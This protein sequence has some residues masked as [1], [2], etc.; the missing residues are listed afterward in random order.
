MFATVPASQTALDS[1]QRLRRVTVEALAPLAIP[2]SIGAI[3]EGSAA[4]RFELLRGAQSGAIGAVDSA[5]AFYAANAPALG[6]A[7]PVL[8]AFAT[9][10]A[11]LIA[12]FSES[13][14]LE[15]LRDRI[16]LALAMP[17][18]TPVARALGPVEAVV[19]AVDDW[20]SVASREVSLGSH[21]Q[22]CIELII[23]WRRLELSSW[24]GLLDRED[25]HVRD[26]G[27]EW[28]FRLFELTIRLPLEANA[29]LLPH[30]SLAAIEGLLRTSSVGEFSRRLD[31]IRSFAAYAAAL[32]D[33]DAGAALVGVA[34]ALDGLVSY[35][36]RFSAPAA[37]EA[38][39][40]R[41]DTMRKVKDVVR[42]ASWRDANILALR[43][44]TNRSHRQLLA[45]ARSYRDKLA[46]PASRHF[47]AEDK[48]DRPMAKLAGPVEPA[49]DLDAALIERAVA[50]GP[51][52]STSAALNG[53]GST[54]RTLDTI[55]RA[56]SDR[57]DPSVT[58]LHELADEVRD[59]A[60]GLSAEQPATAKA[61]T[62]LLTR[63]RRAWADLCQQVRRLGWAQSP[64]LAVERS[65]Q[66]RASTVVI[67]VRARVALD[68][69]T[70]VQAH[71]D[72]ATLPT[73]RSL[74]PA[75]S[76]VLPSTAG[77]GSS[78]IASVRC[79]R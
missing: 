20:E 11:A 76:R 3:D 50:A 4:Y 61:A 17:A 39:Q 72:G 52:R 77:S 64:S 28:W 55:R 27:T 23:A 34:P 78:G 69:L 24:L 31:L 51:L 14:V 9:A 5:D 10:V 47:A 25:R 73:R 1:F 41:E 58:A 44:S 32:A 79:A 35:Y 67:E 59:V 6:Q 42:L 12:R 62:A 54:L 33:T 56:E 74:T 70:S 43:Q 68:W 53:L 71:S 66:D 40:A 38:A 57:T 65:A 48:D 8:A 60:A 26:S 36:A 18:T 29:S 19:V 46:R 49:V 15:Q 30:D 37:A 2:A 13:M 7:Q 75:Q 21:R 45:A 22:A 16:Q 63:K